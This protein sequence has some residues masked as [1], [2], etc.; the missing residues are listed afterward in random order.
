V[1]RAMAIGLSLILL[2]GLGAQLIRSQAQGQQELLQRFLIRSQVGSQFMTSYA[3]DLLS[4][5]R[6]EATAEFQSANVS[7]RRFS[8]LA[9]PLGFSVAVL[10]DAQG[11]VLAIDPPAH[12]L[13]GQEIGT[14]YAH[15]SAAMAG[16][17]SVSNIVSSEAHGEAM[18]AFAVPFSAPSG[19][20]VFSGG[21][22]IADT[23]L[24]TSYLK[25]LL[26]L[27]GAR[28]YLV[29]A[30]GATIASN[31]GGQRTIG[32]MQKRD[33]SLS[34]AITSGQEGRYEASDGAR[35]FASAQV[36]GTPWRLVLSAPEAELLAPVLGAGRWIPR[37]ILVAL[38]LALTVMIGLF[39][40]LGRTVRAHAMAR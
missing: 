8:L 19:R 11:R 30:T 36:A 25:N 13:L 31:L 34:V 40:Q 2:V 32:A 26:P 15:L 9:H 3:G 33:R 37:L 39:R 14:R 6:A 7:E 16:Q 12:N 22:F 27:D 29:D 23:T 20:R 38:F 17:T 1:L 28:V 10:L 5:E 21:L 18:V 35:R 4:K 24:G